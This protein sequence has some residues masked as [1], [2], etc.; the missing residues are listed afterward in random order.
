MRRVVFY[1]LGLKL[2][3]GWIGFFTR[4]GAADERMRSVSSFDKVSPA[5]P[6]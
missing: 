3:D 4:R 5:R 6:D 1:W 2:S